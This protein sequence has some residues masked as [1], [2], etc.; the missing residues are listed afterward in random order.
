V[1]VWGGGGSVVQPKVTIL[2]LFTH[3]HVVSN[4]CHS[5]NTKGKKLKNCTDHCC[6][7]G[8]RICSFLLFSHS[9]Y[10]CHYL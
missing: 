7:S 6:I 5:Y 3:L 4:T 8:S 1:C 2:S 10:L 9:D